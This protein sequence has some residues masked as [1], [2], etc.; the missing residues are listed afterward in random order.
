MHS[1]FDKKWSINTHR[2]RLAYSIYINN[3]MLVFDSPW[4]S[5]QV[6]TSY[7]TEKWMAAGSKWPSLPWRWQPTLEWPM[8]V[9]PGKP[10]VIEHRVKNTWVC[11]EIAMVT[12]EDPT[13]TWIVSEYI[14]TPRPQKSR[15]SSSSTQF[16]KFWLDVMGEYKEVPARYCAH[17]GPRPAT[18][19]M[20][21]R[22][23]WLKKGDQLVNCSNK[24]PISRPARETN[25]LENVGNFYANLRCPRSVQE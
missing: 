20:C 1:S 9:P 22:N 8:A 17:K 16:V 3:S 10:V 14:W 23:M 19:M 15:T 18:H 5:R 25:L 12:T 24:K 6:R 7:A 2:F 4:C 21:G 11:F 13:S